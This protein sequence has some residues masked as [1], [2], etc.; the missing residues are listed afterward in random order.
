MS[1]FI[2]ELSTEFSVDDIWRVGDRRV[3][4]AVWLLTVL[5]LLQKKQHS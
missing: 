3:L 2:C 4:E 5:F 1:H